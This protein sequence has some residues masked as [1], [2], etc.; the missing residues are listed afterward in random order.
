MMATVAQKRQ[1]EQLKIQQRDN[2]IASKFAKLNQWK[3]ELQEKM[4]KK[5]AEVEA[6]KV[7]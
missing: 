7:I 3:K 2:E 6:A 1:E 4:A 5:A